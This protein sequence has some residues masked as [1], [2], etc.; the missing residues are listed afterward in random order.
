M[1][2]TGGE[3]VYP[4]EVEPVLAGHPRVADVA[5][6]GVPVAKWGETVHAV[7]VADPGPDT[8]LDTGELL[9]WARGRPAGYKCPTGVT[10]VPELP[11]NALGKLLR[12]R[13]R[14]PYWS[15]C[16]RRVS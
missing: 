14:E 13:L 9:R 8:S 2:L 12:A 10:V 4:A 7:V 6:I 11:R 15:G 5:V 3:N 1:I 16:K